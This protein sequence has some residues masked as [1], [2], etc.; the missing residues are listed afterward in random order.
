MTGTN[1]AITLPTESWHTYQ[2]QYKNNVTDPSW[3]IL[4]TTFTGNDT[5]E[6]VTTSVS[7]GNGFYKVKAY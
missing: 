5:L 3:S 4:G 6:T 2:L 7:P 1:I